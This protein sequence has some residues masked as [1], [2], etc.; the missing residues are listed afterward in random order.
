MLDSGAPGSYLLRPELFNTRVRGQGND[1]QYG[2]GD[3]S[4]MFD[5]ALHSSFHMTACM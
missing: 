5:C 1:R 3:H 2:E 4:F